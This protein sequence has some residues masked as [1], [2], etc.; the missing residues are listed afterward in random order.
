MV[1]FRFRLANPVP[2][3]RVALSNM[4]LGNISLG[5]ISDWI[6]AKAPEPFLSR[7]DWI[8]SII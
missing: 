3:G 7:Q 6:Q 8:A 1:T 4:I 2:V 5:P